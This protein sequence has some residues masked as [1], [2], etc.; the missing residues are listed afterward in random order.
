[1]EHDYRKTLFDSLKETGL[2]YNFDKIGKAFEYASQMHE[3]QLRKSGE[4]YICHPVAVACIVSQLGLDTDAVCAALLHD[5]LEDCKDRVDIEY[6][7]KNFGEDVVEMVEGLTKFT[8]IHFEE[9][10][11]RALK[12]CARCFSPCPKIFE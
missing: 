7:R 2:P 5:V 9:K 12:I 8:D 1:M 11:M 6:I 10:R 4:P 3:G